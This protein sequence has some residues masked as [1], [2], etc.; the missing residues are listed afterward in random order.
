MIIGYIVSKTKIRNVDGL[1]EQVDDLSKTDPTKPILIVGWEEAKRH[2]MYK[3]I[4]DKELSDGLF[5]TFNRNESRSDME[6]DI[7]SFCKFAYDSLAKGIT[8]CYV[9]FFT[10]PYNKF[11]NLIR[12]LSSSSKERYIYIS[13]SMMYVPCNGSVLGISLSILGYCG[14]SRDKVIGFIK[15]NNANKVIDDSVWWVEKVSRNVRDRLYMV[16][17]LVKK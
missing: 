7:K 9:N 14:V 2:P 4:L 1:V 13:N 3:T 5:W 16:P 10:L 11:R 15:S 12:I 8:Y 6:R 17:S